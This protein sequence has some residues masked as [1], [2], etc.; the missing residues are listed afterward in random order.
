MQELARMKEK[1]I[2]VLKSLLL[3][4]DIK[5]ATATDVS[6]EKRNQIVCVV[7]SKNQLILRYVTETAEVIL[8]KVDWFYQ[9]E[10]GSS[11]YWFSNQK[12]LVKHLS[13][14]SFDVFLRNLKF[15]KIFIQKCKQR[16]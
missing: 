10:K 7:T 13:G 16:K 11:R 1:E 14:S 4:V 3:N 15:A 9:N 5:I 2:L 6:S 8:K 12:S